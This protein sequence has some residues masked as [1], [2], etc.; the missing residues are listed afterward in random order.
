MKLQ[1]EGGARL[2]VQL[3]GGRSCVKLQLEASCTTGGGA[4]LAILQLEGGARL[5]LQVVSGLG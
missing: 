1:L 4:R 5:A 3:G 2:A